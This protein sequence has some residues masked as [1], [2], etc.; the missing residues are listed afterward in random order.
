MRCASIFWL[1]TL[2]AFFLSPSASSEDLTPTSLDAAVEHLLE[3]KSIVFEVGTH[4]CIWVYLTS[5]LAVAE[6]CEVTF[7]PAQARNVA[8]IRNAL[9]KYILDN[10]RDRSEAEQWMARQEQTSTLLSRSLTPPECTMADYP[11]YLSAKPAA[12]KLLAS[13]AVRGDPF[14]GGCL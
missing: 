9:E 8:T 3:Q 13:L 14:A 6:R 2:G 10:A 1:F 7:E 12:E 5:G 11:K 4:A